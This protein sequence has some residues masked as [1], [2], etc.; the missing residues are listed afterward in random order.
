M[1]QVKLSKE[2]LTYEFTHSF[3]IDVL[4][5]AKDNQGVSTYT[6]INKSTMTNNLKK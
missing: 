4:T 5:W 1:S 6:D 2:F 3:I